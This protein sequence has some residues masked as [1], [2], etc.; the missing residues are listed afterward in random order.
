MHLGRTWSNLHWVLAEECP[1]VRD[2]CGSRSTAKS[3]KT[4]SKSDLDWACKS[5]VPDEDSEDSEKYLNRTWR[6][7]YNTWT[8]PEDTD[9]IPEAYLMTLIHTW[10]EPVDSDMI[11][12]VHLMTLIQTWWLWYDTWSLPERTWTTWMNLIDKPDHL[13]WP[14]PGPDVTWSWSDAQTRCFILTWDWPDRR[15]YLRVLM[16]FKWIA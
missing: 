6:H 11:P 13:I 5:D 2:V 12:A 15:T 9:I 8:E 14:W 7:W 10:S 16:H 1:W 4:T 3:L